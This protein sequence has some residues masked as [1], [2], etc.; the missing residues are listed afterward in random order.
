MD[1]KRWVRA[2][3][4]SRLASL[5]WICAVALASSVAGVHAQSA[6]GSSSDWKVFDVKY[7]PGRGFCQGQCAVHIYAGRETSTNMTSMFALDGV[8]TF[9][10]EKFKPV[11][12]WNYEKSGLVAGAVSRRLMTVLRFIDVEGEIGIG[13]RFG[14]MDE[15]EVWSAL[16]LRWTWF[17]WNSY[18][19]TTIATSTG[20][21]YASD[22]S[23]YERLRDGNRRGSNLL[24]FFSPEL[25]LAL[26]SQPQWELV[27]RIHHRSGGKI[28]FGEIPMFNGV[29]GG[30][31]FGTL[32]IRYRF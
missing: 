12:D 31:H 20:V 16:F 29:D 15:T 4:T 9:A 11:W 7:T 24:H 30:A 21:N 27:A 1:R 2:I 17:P 5:I 8:A 28:L 22:I 26:P 10:P 6:A 19:K 14:R 18:L 13:Q 3:V 23:P 32:G 25:T